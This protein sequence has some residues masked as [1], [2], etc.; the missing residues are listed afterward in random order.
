MTAQTKPKHG[1]VTHYYPDG[2]VRV[3]YKFRNG[4]RHGRTTCYRPDGSVSLIHN[5]RN[6]SRHGPQYGDLCT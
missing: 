6:D 3:I 5:Y 4:K 1:R 2:S